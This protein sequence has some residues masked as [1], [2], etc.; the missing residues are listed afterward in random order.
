MDIEKYKSID[1][2]S[3]AYSMFSSTLLWFYGVLIFI[4]ILITYLIN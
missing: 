2:N 4:M 1:R 3:W